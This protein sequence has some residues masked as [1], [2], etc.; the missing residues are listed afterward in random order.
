MSS[1]SVGAAPVSESSPRAETY[2]LP[3]MKPRDIALPASKTRSMSIDVTIRF[4]TPATARR[5]VSAARYRGWDIKRVGSLVR[6]HG[7]FPYEVAAL[8]DDLGI[9]VDAYVI[10][11]AS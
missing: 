9:P 3:S 7:A 10:E 2:S 6:I 5:F 8:A 11:V 1:K 4:L